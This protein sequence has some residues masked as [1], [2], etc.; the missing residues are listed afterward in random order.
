MRFIIYRIIFWIFILS[1]GLCVIRR[2]GIKNKKRCGAILAVM[3]MVMMSLSA[4]VPV[5]NAF[6]TFSTVED[7]YCYMHNENIAATSNGS[8]TALVIGRDNE[9][10]TFSAVLRSNDGWKLGTGI[11]LSSDTIVSDGIVIQIYRYQNTADYYIT[12]EAADGVRLNVSDSVGSHYQ[13]MINEDTVSGEQYYM[14]YVCVTAPAESYS[15]NVNNR[16][17]Q[18]SLSE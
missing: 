7:A 4:M 16:L 9:K 17:V 10:Y 13:C 12:V 1:L 15:V 5:E 6:V 3:S 8:Q 2:S 14:Y 18:L 11:G